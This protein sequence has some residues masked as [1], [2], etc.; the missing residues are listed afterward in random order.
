MHFFRQNAVEESEE[1]EALFKQT[2]TVAQ[3][4]ATKC[5]RGETELRLEQLRDVKARLV[6]CR[7]DS[8]SRLKLLQSVVPTSD[9]LHT[10][11]VELTEWLQV[12]ENMLDNHRV[13]GDITLVEERL[14]RHAVSSRLR[15]V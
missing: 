5:D 7:Q 4:L 9:S 11:T 13:E 1:K 12:A 15:S 8:L 3:A 2:S 6:R 10:A 14:G